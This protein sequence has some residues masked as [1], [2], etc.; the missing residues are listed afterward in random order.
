M[1]AQKKSIA[2]S[3]RTLDTV[4]VPENIVAHHEKADKP[5]RVHSTVSDVQ[6]QNGVCV[7]NWKPKRP[8]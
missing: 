3:C 5:L 4:R 2:K 6:C 7:L 8:A 1:Y